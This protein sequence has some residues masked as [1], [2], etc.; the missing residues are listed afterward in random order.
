MILISN[1][2]LLAAAL[3]AIFY[4]FVVSRR[5]GG[6]KRQSV[7]LTEKLGQLDETVSQVRAAILEGR[8]LATA[9][10]A[11]LESLC[12]QADR[13]RN[14]LR[15]ATAALG[16]TIAERTP[17]LEEDDGD[18]HVSRIKRLQRRQ[19]MRTAS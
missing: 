9:E 16:E 7:D 8:A 11:R 18:D 5:L 6:L 15:R 10:D 13:L 14:D 2:L 4:C 19:K 3:A 1:G 12:K 17:P